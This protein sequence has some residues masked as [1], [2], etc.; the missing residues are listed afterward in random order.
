MVINKNSQPVILV[1]GRDGQIGQ[2][3]QEAFHE[4]NRTV[5]FLGRTDCD[6]SDELSIQKI[7]HHYEPT[8]IINAAAYTVVDAAELNAKQAFAIN[9]RAPALMAK[10][11]AN[12]SHGVFLHY[13]TEYVFADT[14]A[15]A[16]TEVD[17]AG[18]MNLL[19]IYGQSKLLGEQAIQEGFAGDSQVGTDSV[20]QGPRYYILRTSGVYGAGNNFIRTMLRLA[21]QQDS[22]RVV[23]DQVGVPTSAEWLAQMTLGMLNS[24]A[25]SG[26]YHVVPD[27]EASWYEV[28]VFAVETAIAAGASIEISKE[29]ILPILSKEYAALAKRP[30]NSRLNHDKFKQVWD[31]MELEKSYPFWQEQVSSYVRQ[32][33][34]NTGHR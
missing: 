30:H 8:V 32:L 28:A 12:L 9:A 6:L 4:L 27:G 21:Q 13:S 34:K 7:L 31:A 29:E 11:M 16:Y 10:Y 22:L 3:L 24:D 23:M 18:P 20:N 25:N 17:R 19:N 2:A 26:I 15:S 14:Q 5:I 1:F 33:L